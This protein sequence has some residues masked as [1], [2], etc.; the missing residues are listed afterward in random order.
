VLFAPPEKEE[1]PPPLNSKPEIIKIDIVIWEFHQQS[2][3][4][5]GHHDPERFQPERQ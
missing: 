3:T 5:R 2:H 4:R 1:E